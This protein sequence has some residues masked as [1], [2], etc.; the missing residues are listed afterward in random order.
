[1][2]LGANTSKWYFVGDSSSLERATKRSEDSL[3]RL[4]RTGKSAFGGLASSAGALTGLLGVGGLAYGLKGL[5]DAALESEKAA[6]RMRTQFEALGIDFEAHRQRVDDVIQA[7]SRLAALDDEDLSDSFTTILRVTGDVNRSLELNALAADIARGRQI[8]LAAAGEIVAKVAGGNVGILSRYGIS[9][10]KGASA[11][12]ALGELQRLFAGQAEAYGASNAG[13]ADRAAVA[14]ENAREALGEKLLPILAKVATFIADDLIPAVSSFAGTVDSIVDKLGGWKVAAGF[15]LS[16]LLASRILGIVSALKA[17]PAAAATAAAA[18]TGAG[19][20]GALASF[21]RFALPAAAAAGAIAMRDQ[22][23]E[24]GPLGDVGNWVRENIFGEVKDYAPE[25]GRLA[26]YRFKEAFKKDLENVDRGGGDFGFEGP[27]RVL[28]AAGDDAG[29][30]TAKAF[31]LSLTA[32]LRVKFPT[33]ANAALAPTWQDIARAAEAAG[34]DVGNAFVSGYASAVVNASTGTNQF[35]NVGSYAVAPGQQLQGTIFPIAAGVSTSI[36]GTPGSGTHNQTDWQSRNAIDIAATPGTPVLAVEDGTIDHTGG[37]DPARGTVETSSGKKLY[38]W[39]VTLNGVSGTQYFYTHLDKLA[40]SAGDTVKAGDVIGLVAAWKGGT[41]HVHF[42]TSKGDPRNIGNRVKVDYV[43]PP[44][45]TKTPG[46]SSPTSPG[47]TTTPRAKTSFPAIAGISD[48]LQG[49]FDAANQPEGEALQYD[50]KTKKWVAVKVGPDMKALKRLADHLRT[51]VLPGIQ[52]RI[53][54]LKKRIQ[55]LVKK[56]A[57]SVLIQTL[58]NKLEALR[59]ERDEIAGL[60]REIIDTWKDLKEAAEEDD[61][62][63]PEPTQAYDYSGPVG[64]QPGLPGHETPDPTPPDTTPDLRAEL[65]QAN[66]R[67]A[68]SARAAQ[69]SGAFVSSLGI[70][71]DANGNATVT[72]PGGVTVNMSMAFPPSPEQAVLIGQAVA[73]A[74]SGQGFQPSTAE[75]L[76]V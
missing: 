75:S 51:K 32:F 4:N 76:G 3:D 17:I 40:V 48:S 25:D 47:S 18:S 69:L 67:A 9:I 68:A 43:P 13:A 1:M 65:D 30:E 6:A 8:E 73:K 10:E 15:I 71:V 21:M 44:P 45:S 34:I 24:K 36:I 55:A 19:G 26:S 20:L 64:G 57:D 38:G 58:R 31:T 33:M 42:A 56:K 37:A 66:R 16:G 52:K 70:G 61:D 7:Q 74:A 54:V 72:A 35:A 50:P 63:G 39:S 29:E 14:W 22:F 41:A 28:E 12:E 53:D 23:S 27:A 59:S 2:A 11:T 46:T 5:T 49:R 60:W 62:T